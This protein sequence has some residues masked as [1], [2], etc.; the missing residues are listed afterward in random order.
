MAG[1]RTISRVDLRGCLTFLVNQY[2]LMK[3]SVSALLVGAFL[4]GSTFT[5]HAASAEDLIKEHLKAIGGVEAHKKIKTRVLKG[6]LDIP[7]QGVTAAMIIQTKAPN[8]MRTELE[9]PG[10]GKIVEG[11]DGKVAWSNNPFTGLTEKPADQQAQA[12]RQADFYRDV[13]LLDRYESWTLKGEETVNGKST[14]VLEGKSKEGTTDTFYLDEKTHLIVQMKTR[15]SGSDATI[16]LSDHR[17]VDGLKVPFSIEFDA[18]AA[19]NF[20]L[21]IDE[22]QHGVTL[23]DALFAF[24]SK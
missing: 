14:H 24:P 19:G 6:K 1:P 7:A 17:T 23:D 22:V 4:A 20:S 2:S 10:V 11:F 21:K 12:K 13:E 15:E 9:F 3:I 8:K 16:Q 5:I 18:G